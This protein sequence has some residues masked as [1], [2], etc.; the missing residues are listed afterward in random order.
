MSKTVAEVTKISVM[1]MVG[2][3]GSRVAPEDEMF[4]GAEA[5]V[6]RN[7]NPG[8]VKIVPIIEGIKTGMYATSPKFGDCKI[9][10]VEED[11][12]SVV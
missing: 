10:R 12:K 7:S 5:H 6:S 2:E 9:A 1:N 8:R 4:A 11:R 3:D